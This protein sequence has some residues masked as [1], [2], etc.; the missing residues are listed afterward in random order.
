MVDPYQRLLEAT[1][2][3]LFGLL[4]EYLTVLT[5]SVRSLIVLNSDI[6]LNSENVE[7]GR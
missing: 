4:S 1:G 5:A 2:I 7:V 3:V 6:V